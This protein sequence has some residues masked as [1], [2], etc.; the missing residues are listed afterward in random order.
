MDIQNTINKVVKFIG[1]VGT[2]LGDRRFWIVAMSVAIV[3][4]KL[5]E[6]EVKTYAEAITTVVG[7]LALIVGWTWRPPSGLDYKPVTSELQDLV[8]ALEQLG[9]KVTK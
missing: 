7:S 6:A 8:D 4:F 1:K 9:I 2:V 5:P 3:F